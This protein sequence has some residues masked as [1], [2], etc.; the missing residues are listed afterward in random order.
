M[1][2]LQGFII[3]FIVSCILL[4]SVSAFAESI[5]ALFNVVNIKINGTQVAKIGD[6]YTLSNGEKVPFSISYK[7]TTYLPMRKLAELLGKE[8][9]WDDKTKTVIVN[10]KGTISTS[11]LSET[12]ASKGFSFTNPAKINDFFN[13][14][15]T[16]YKVG[17]TGTIDFNIG[18]TEVISGDEAWNIIK[19]ADKY[20]DP[21]PNGQKYILA[22]FKIKINNLSNS[23][24]FG[25]YLLEFEEYNGNGVK[26]ENEYRSIHGLKPSFENEITTNVEYEGYKVF[27]VDSSDENPVVA[28]DL[29]SNGKKLFFSIA[30]ISKSTSTSTSIK[31]SSDKYTINSLSDLK[32]FLENNFSTLQTCIGTTR[33]TFD[34]YENTMSIEPY[35]YWIKVGYEYEF[36]EGAMISIKYTNEQKDKLRQELKDHQEKLAKAVI[37][38]MP[39]KKFYGCYYKSWYKYPNLKIDLQTRQY[40]SWT[41]YDEP[42]ILN[43]DVKDIYNSTKPSTFRWYPIIDD[44][45]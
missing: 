43:I 29:E 12:T 8:V 22:K 33:F 30:P 15:M 25:L 32:Q 21:A 39:N 23:N 45:L 13:V 44:E 34:I 41:N 6:S 10:D 20:N 9:A 26:Y 5:N 28:L 2:R 37:T 16:M 17:Y 7:G 42:D 14:K 4:S 11:E 35:D 1:K 18:L 40:Y 24:S 19:S 31:S 27:I 3:G 38:A 36:F